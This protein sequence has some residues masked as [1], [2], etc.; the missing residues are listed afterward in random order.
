MKHNVTVLDKRQQA[1]LWPSHLAFILHPGK[2]EI[3]AIKA[4][5]SGA[6]VVPDQMV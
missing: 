4:G 2:L 1:Q 5:A 6:G 3:P